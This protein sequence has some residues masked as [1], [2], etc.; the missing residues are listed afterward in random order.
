MNFL[1]SLFLFLVKFV[2]GKT[3]IKLFR[4][5][6][7][8]THQQQQHPQKPNTRHQP[9]ITKLSLSYMY[10]EVYKNGRKSSPR[11]RHF[12]FARFYFHRF[13]RAPVFLPFYLVILFRL[14]HKLLHFFFL[15]F[16]TFKDFTWFIRINK[17]EIDFL[18]LLFSS[19]W[20]LIYA[21]RD[22]T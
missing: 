19:V 21:W 6:V 16:K 20:H 22:L 8:P 12:A 1:I 14:A 4:L 10:K 7:P 15:N 11:L 2:Y 17:D 5:S 9:F 18:T 13:S 3:I